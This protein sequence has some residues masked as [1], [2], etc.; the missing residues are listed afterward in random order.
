M[1]IKEVVSYVV[2]LGVLGLMAY[3]IARELTRPSAVIV[4]PTE[5]GGW[6]IV[7]RRTS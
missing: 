6:M 5:K 2:I 4:E 3:V 7:E 1:E